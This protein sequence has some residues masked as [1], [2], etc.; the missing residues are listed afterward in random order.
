MDKILV[1]DKSIDDDEID[2][3]FVGFSSLYRSIKIDQLEPN[4]RI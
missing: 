1:I 2:S 4:I 3:I